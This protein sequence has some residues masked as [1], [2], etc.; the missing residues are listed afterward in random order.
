MS[1]ICSPSWVLYDEQRFR[2]CT[3]TIEPNWNRSSGNR[4]LVPVGGGFGKAF[5]INRHP[6]AFSVQAYYNAA[7]PE[8]APEWSLR[9]GFVGHVPQALAE[10]AQ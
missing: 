3:G 8:G 1:P 6:W 10:R 7:R 9:L 2:R 4:W 5:K